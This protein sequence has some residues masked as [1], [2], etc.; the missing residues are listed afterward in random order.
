MRIIAGQYRSRKLKFPKTKA[1]RPAMDRV[2]ET[3]FNIIGDEIIGA[4]VLD[5]YAGCGS[6]GFEALSRGAQSAFFV[7]VHHQAVKCIQE[8]SALLDV[9]VSITIMQMLVSRAIPL[10]HKKGSLFDFI[11]IDP[12][13]GGE[14]AKKTLMKLY[15]FGILAPHGKMIIEHSAHDELALTNEIEVIACKK[16]GET[17]VSFL[18]IQ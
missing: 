13:Y 8:N 14:R 6:I 5:L 9:K 3:I 7:E 15:R 11:F 18:K 10:L 2:R 12:P 17:I 1:V 4:R 16:F